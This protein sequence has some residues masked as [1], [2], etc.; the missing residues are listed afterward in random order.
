MKMGSSPSSSPWTKLQIARG[1]L[2]TIS[3]PVFLA[4]QDKIGYLVWVVVVEGLDPSQPTKTT[5]TT[6]T[7]RGE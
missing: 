7:A 5:I 1:D 6:W 4:F 2:I 3:L